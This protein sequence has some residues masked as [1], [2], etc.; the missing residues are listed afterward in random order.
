MN[1]HNDLNCK[2]KHTNI[3]LDEYSHLFL[4]QPNMVPDLVRAKLCEPPQASW[5][6]GTPLR[7][8]ISMGWACLEPQP[9]PSW[10][11]SLL[12]QENSRPSENR[13]NNTIWFDWQFTSILGKTGLNA[14]ALRVISKFTEAVRENNFRFNRIF[15]LKK[16]FLCKNALKENAKRVTHDWPVQTSQA[17]LGLH[18]MH[19]H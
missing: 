8:L 5:D 4:P 15:L 10:P 11:Q 1:E 12:P 18:F 2:D 7:L 19:M 6:T 17:N 3:H 14:C 16:S 9:T 13:T